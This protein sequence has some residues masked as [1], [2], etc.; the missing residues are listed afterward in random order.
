M[1][2]A[3]PCLLVSLLL[4]SCGPKED[5]EPTK[6]ALVNAHTARTGVIHITMRYAEVLGAGASGSDSKVLDWADLAGFRKSEE[7]LAARK[8]LSEYSKPISVD[9]GSRR[10]GEIEEV[11]L[12][13]A[14]LVNLA[15]EPRGTWESFS[16]EITGARSRLDRAVKALETG[17]KDFVLIEARTETN[18]ASFAY[19]E[20]IARAKAADS[21]QP[22]KT[23]PAP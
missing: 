14:A 3:V 6:R 1:R 9:P 16:Q 2:R 17:T 18:K 23:N 5:Y 22:G 4:A 8:L 7:G 13:T 19:A 11:S 10:R 21:A 12:A 15:L 20:T